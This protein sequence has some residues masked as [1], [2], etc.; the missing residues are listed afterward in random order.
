[1]RM[2][3]E[4]CSQRRHRPKPRTAEWPEAEQEEWVLCKHAAC[5][6]RGGCCPVFCSNTWQCQC[7]S[8]SAVVPPGKQ[9]R[10]AT[11]A[12]E[13]TRPSFGRAP[14]SFLYTCQREKTATAFTWEQMGPPRQPALINRRDKRAASGRRAAQ[15]SSLAEA[16]PGRSAKPGEAPDPARQ[17]RGRR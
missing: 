8:T 14:V 9:R 17:L 5:G 15:R 11:L 13:T 10:N 12:Q 2:C 4:S 7:G 6:H 16:A 3:L 1:M